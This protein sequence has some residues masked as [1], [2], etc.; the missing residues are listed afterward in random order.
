MQVT[1][2][3]PEATFSAKEVAP[4]SRSGSRLLGMPGEGPPRLADEPRHVPL[5]LLVGPG[6][7]EREPAAGDA[8]EGVRGGRVALGYL[9]D[10]HRARDQVL[11]QAPVLHREEHGGEARPGELPEDVPGKLAGPVHL[12]G[13]GSELLAAYPGHRL[14]NRLLFRREIAHALSPSSLPA[15]LD[16]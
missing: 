12:R 14:P 13:S 5:L 8:G 3:T 4:A 11:A 2:S 16:G 15:P 6:E 7:Q 10:D 9:L 1:L